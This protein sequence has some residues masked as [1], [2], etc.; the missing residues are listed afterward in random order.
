MKSTM[1]RYICAGGLARPDIDAL[2]NQGVNLD[3]WDYMLVVP[4]DI[5]EESEL[6]SG[7][8][9]LQPQDWHIQQLLI[10]LCENKWYKVRFHGKTVGVGIAY[11][12]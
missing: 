12:A 9:D 10:G 5:L 7:E 11:H 8:K 4:A 1:I 3:D 6:D 2:W